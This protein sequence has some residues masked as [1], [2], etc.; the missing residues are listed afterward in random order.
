MRIQQTQENAARIEAA[1]AAQ[2]MEAPEMPSVEDREAQRQHDE[3]ELAKAR[4]HYNTNPLEAFEPAIEIQE[5]G[6]T[7]EET[8][9]HVEERK[10]GFNTL[11]MQQRQEEEA[12]LRAETSEYAP[13]TGKTQEWTPSAAPRRR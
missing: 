12:K 11:E 2:R 6:K 1:F 3:A 13:G 10:H 4:D 5:A 8:I 7:P 9:E